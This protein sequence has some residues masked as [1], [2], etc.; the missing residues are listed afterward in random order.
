M[1]RTVCMHQSLLFSPDL[2]FLVP[3]MLPGSSMYRVHG[4]LVHFTFLGWHRKIC[5]IQTNVATCCG[6]ATMPVEVHTTPLHL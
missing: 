3:G 1:Q 6:A 5:T 2:M 4:L